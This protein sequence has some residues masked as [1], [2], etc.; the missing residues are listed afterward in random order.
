M[1]TMRDIQ[2]EIRNVLDAVEDGAELTDKQRAQIDGY[3]AELATAEADKVDAF[4]AVL[5]REKARVEFL[6]SEEKR[7]SSRRA[8]VERVVEHMRA[9][10]LAVMVDAGRDRLKGNTSS[11]GVQTRTVLVVD[12]VALL[13]EPLRMAHATTQYMPD[14]PAITRL[15]V[16]GAAVP[17]AH[18]E[19]RQ[20]LVVR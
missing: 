5:R 4:A 16:S 8:S 9:R 20:H 18:I 6:R 17:G 13:P 12:D 14:T 3:L 15:L 1:P 2:A 10:Y 19:E 11:I 7:V